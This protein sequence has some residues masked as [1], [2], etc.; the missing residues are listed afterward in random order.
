[1]PR[2]KLFF[3]CWYLC[4]LLVSDFARA[5]SD[6]FI[7][8]AALEDKDDIQTNLTGS[9]IYLNNSIDNDVSGDLKEDVLESYFDLDTTLT[10]TPSVSF[11]GRYAAKFSNTNSFLEETSVLESYL[12]YS[13]PSSRVAL[14]TGRHTLNWSSG[15]NWEPTNLLEPR[16]LT[17]SNGEFDIFQQ[18]GWDLIKLD[19]SSGEF[20][21]NILVA[22]SPVD[23]VSG[24]QVAGR[25][26]YNGNFDAAF[27]A[28]NIGDYSNKVG[29]SLG[30]PFAKGNVLHSEFIHTRLNGSSIDDVDNWGLTVESLSGKNI[31]NELLIGV[32]RYYESGHNLSF[33]YFY[34]GRGIDPKKGIDFPESIELSSATS[35]QL[36]NRI[37]DVSS[38]Y[39]V[40]K[41]YLSLYTEYQIKGGD[42]S[43]TP[44]LIYNLGDDSRYLSMNYKMN[45]GSNSVL[46]FEAATNLGSDD[47]EFGQADV[48]SYIRVAATHH[49]F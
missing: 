14:T 2:W 3:F 18:K 13:E 46:Q 40:G 20:T 39:H 26:S 44:V 7:N 33:E 11:A 41:E 42:S 22:S 34:N 10:M 12:F 37:G 47:S 6:P 31:F 5:E 23:Y 25:S 17:K 4:I 9:F 8:Q 27:Y 30:A 48:G 36:I 45:F 15:F 49:F 21:N 35:Q 43:V 32:S 16:Y 1:M 19:Y 28:A 38:K 29:F 24:A